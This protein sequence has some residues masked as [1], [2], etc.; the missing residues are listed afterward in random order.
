MRNIKFGNGE[1]KA[2]ISK[3]IFN[4]SSRYYLFSEKQKPE[5]RNIFTVIR[6]L[7]KKFQKIKYGV[8]DDRVWEIYFEFKKNKDKR[9]GTGGKIK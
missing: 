2:V 4:Y 6:Y 5:V 1:E 8:E 9:Y 3:K 7:I